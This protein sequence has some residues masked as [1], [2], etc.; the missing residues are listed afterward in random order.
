MRSYRLMT[1]AL[2]GALAAGSA[3][4]AC[5]EVK[6]FNLPDET[7]E[8]KAAR[9][10]WWT[11][12]RFGMF[13]HFGLYAM[14]GR[15]EWVKS[16]ESIPDDVYDGKYFTRFDPKRLDA[17]KW[18][19][20]AK[21]AGMKYAV[22]TAKH[23]EGFCLWD[24]KVT[25]YKSTNTPFGRDIVREFVE[26]FRAEGLRVGFYYS[27]I[28]WHHPDYTLDLAT[29]CHKGIP[30]QLFDKLNALPDREK[31]LKPWYDKVAPLNKG[32][33]MARYRQYMK[34]QV[35]ELLTN[36]GKIDILWFD[37][38]CADEYTGKG[39]TDWDSEGL[40]TLVRKLQPGI[41]VNCRLDL[42]DDPRG[43]DFLTPEQ[44]SLTACPVMNGR[45]VAWE[46]CQTFSGSWGYFRDELT[47]KTASQIVGQLP[48][49]VGLGGN[50]IM[51]VGPNGQGEIDER[52]LERLADYGKWMSRNGEAIYGCGEPPD[53]FRAPNGT[54]L[55]Y[56]AKTKRLYLHLLEWPVKAVP[57]PFWKRIAYAQFLHDG[58][59]V[60]VS[61]PQWRLCD[62]GENKDAL[63][64]TLDLPV[65]KPP[66]E[67]P[68][69]ELFL[70]A[71]SDR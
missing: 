29:H 60:L 4:T 62:H 46:T 32:R 57:V 41:L 10:A 16:L 21:E 58:S 22:L 66:V 52:A 70:K 24:S 68:V 63:V 53:E 19:K 36:Y 50:L 61:N 44:K 3:V 15:H 14:A 35:T 59:E 67:V 34:D 27:L 28:D 55:T 23:H 18:A 65:N 69:V 2:A 39:R 1:I 26:A 71:A 47:W 13:I 45:K 31:H 42:L 33:D 38:S 12:A 64:G 6:R 54:A 7:E 5:G 43:Y 11:E 48:K 37:F 56:N 20:A 17:K 40:L 9:M 51:N 49:T 30:W 25:D 8:A